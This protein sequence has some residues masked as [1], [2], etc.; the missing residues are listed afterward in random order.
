MAYPDPTVDVLDER[1]IAA[2]VADELP[3]GVWVARVPNGEFLYANRE[4]Q[5]IMGMAARADVAAGEYAAPYGICDREGNPYP[6]Q[7]MPFVQALIAGTTVVVDDIVIHRSDGGRVNI[8]ASA[9]PVRDATGAMRHIIV[10]FIDIS[11]EVVAE[12][13]RADSERRLRLGQRMEAIGNLAGGI[14]HD[15]NNLLAGLKLL[16]AELGGSE[17]D[18]DRLS[19]FQAIDELTDRAAT[20]TR[21]LLGFAGRGKHRSAPVGLNPLVSGLAEIFRRTLLGVATIETR[22]DASG[23]GVVI[24]DASQ[25]EQVVMNLVVNARDAVASSGRSGHI[26]VGTRRLE[27]APGATAAVGPGRWLVLEVVDDGPGI[28]ADLR[29]RVFEPY[30]TT[31]TGGPSPGSGLGLATV[32]G[33]VDRHGGTVVLDDPPAGRGA[34]V[35]VYLP[36][37]DLERL[38]VPLAAAGPGRVMGSGAVLVVDDEPL[39]RTAMAR[40]LALAGYD[41]SQVGSGPEAIEL[42]RARPDR[43]RAVVLDLVMPGMN[44]RATYQALRVIAPDIAVLVVSGNAANDEVQAILDLGARAFLA[45]PCSLEALSGAVAAIMAGAGSTPSTPG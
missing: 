20:L 8:R 38:P 28:P 1:Q 3:V 12:T 27:V 43:F 22:L 33:V 34:L 18:P 5:E 31:R 15:F 26:V 32:F 41:V 19:A 9:R 44:G 6:E 11:R 36:A 2:A 42:F 16:A 17:R 4:F 10:A 21:A 25:L 24:G 30:F 23:D 7:R 35:R 39:V 14:A 29:E 40:V 13:A 45:K 37:A